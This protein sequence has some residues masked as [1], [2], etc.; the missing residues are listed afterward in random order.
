MWS[1]IIAVITLYN[2]KQIRNS[3]PRS[4]QNKQSSKILAQFGKIIYIK[5]YLSLTTSLSF[6]QDNAKSKYIF[7]KKKLCSCIRMLN[8]SLN[9]LKLIAKNRDIHSCKRMSKN[10]LLSIL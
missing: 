2:L 3:H 9:E 7:T 4:S 5:P 10:K 6:A 8:L 1:F